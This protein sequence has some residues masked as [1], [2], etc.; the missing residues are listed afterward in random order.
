MKCVVHFK[1]LSRDWW[2]ARAMDFQSRKSS[3]RLSSDTVSRKSGKFMLNGNVGRCQPGIFL[4]IFLYSEMVPDTPKVF[5]KDSINLHCLK[6]WILTTS[7]FRDERSPTI[8][9]P[10]QSML[11]CNFGVAGHYYCSHKH[12]DYSHNLIP[13]VSGIIPQQ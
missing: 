4:W 7:H 2:I 12:V 1:I 3:H 13:L 8:E 5:K 9:Q 6:N 11:F 10:S